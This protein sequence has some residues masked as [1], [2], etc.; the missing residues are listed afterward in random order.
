MLRTT[1]LAL[2]FC[3]AGT[4]AAQTAARPDPAEPRAAA[5][6]PS[7]DSAFKDYRPYVDPEIARWRDVNQEVGRLN[8]HVGHV[9]QQPGIAAKPAAKSPVQGGHG[10]HK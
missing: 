3:F 9:P 8:G 4:T 10:A 5:P 2:A 7:Y 6:A 1:C